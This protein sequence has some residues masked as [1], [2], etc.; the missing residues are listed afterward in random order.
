[1][2]VKIQ[3]FD[4]IT[5]RSNNL[6]PLLRILKVNFSDDNFLVE[7]NSEYV[8]ELDPVIL[9]KPLPFSS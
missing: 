4:K 3:S 5:S 1:M 8:S 6:F 2:L 7:N 9:I